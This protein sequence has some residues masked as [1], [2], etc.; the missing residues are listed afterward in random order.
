[1][2]GFEAEGLILVVRNASFAF[3]AAIQGIGRVKLDARLGGEHLHH[4]S[5][6]GLINP[7]SQRRRARIVPDHIIVIV[8]FGIAG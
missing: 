6:L 5:A 7:G 4:T 2:L 8:S 1:M 3:Q